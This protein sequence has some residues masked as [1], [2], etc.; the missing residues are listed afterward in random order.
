[1]DSPGHARPHGA[2]WIYFALLAIGTL[3]QLLRVKDPLDFI[4]CLFF[5]FGLVGVFG[6]L[7]QYAIG[8]RAFWKG[9]FI[10]S[11]ATSLIDVVSTLFQWDPFSLSLVVALSLPLYYLLWMCAYRSSAAWEALAK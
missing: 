3:L 11:A 4:S 5:L 6:Y 9:Y 2:W 8:W 10:V 7:C 1:M